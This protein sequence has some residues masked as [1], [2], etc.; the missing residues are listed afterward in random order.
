MFQYPEEASAVGTH[1]TLIGSLVKKQ[2][3]RGPSYYS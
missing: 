1:D 3:V 2:F